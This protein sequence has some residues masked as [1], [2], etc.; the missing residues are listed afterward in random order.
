MYIHT[1]RR[2]RERERERERIHTKNEK[3]RNDH[4]ILKTTP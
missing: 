2:E 3:I 4:M 1:Q